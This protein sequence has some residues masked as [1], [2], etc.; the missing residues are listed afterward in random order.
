MNKKNLKTS[1][2]EAV[3]YLAAMAITFSVLHRTASAQGSTNIS[4]PAYELINNN[5]VANQGS[6]FVY[7][8]QDSG[9]NH[10]FPSGFMGTDQSTITLNAGC[11]DSSSSS[12]GCS[13]DPT[14]LDRVHGTV[15]SISFAAQGPGNWAGLAIEEPQGWLALQYGKGYNLTGAL[16]LLSQTRAL[17]S[18][19]VGCASMVGA[20]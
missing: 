7:L 4:T 12:T 1:W 16:A 6:F 11:I 8:D 10:G 13:S 3:L 14:V 2:A 18:H 19:A 9:Q 17:F 5:A 20:V 15:I